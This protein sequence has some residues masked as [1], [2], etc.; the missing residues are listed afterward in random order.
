MD[1]Q[2]HLFEFFPEGLYLLLLRDRN[3]HQL[4]CV[5]KCWPGLVEYNQALTYQYLC[6]DKKQSF[7]ALLLKLGQ[8]LYC[9]TSAKS[10]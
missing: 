8:H 9:Y 6:Q 2:Q 5:S 4:I 3:L 1:H 10:L 7:F